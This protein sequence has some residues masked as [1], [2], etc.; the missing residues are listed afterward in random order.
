MC[1]R[2]ERATASRLC[3]AAVRSPVVRSLHRT[4]E[5]NFA[6]HFASLPR[7]MPTPINALSY[8]ERLLVRVPATATSFEIINIILIVIDA[9]LF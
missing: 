9:L 8:F 6:L 5:S 4:A 3:G 2:G 7:A 1:A